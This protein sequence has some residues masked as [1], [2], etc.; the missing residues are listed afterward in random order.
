MRTKPLLMALI[1]LVSLSASQY[2]SPAASWTVGVSKGDYFY[3]KTY[4]AYT[5]NLPNLTLKI[6]QFEYNNTAWLRITVAN[7]SSLVV[8]QAYTLHFKNGSESTFSF[9]TNLNPQNESA[10]KFTQKGVPICAANLKAGDPLPT[11]Q[12]TINKTVIWAYPSGSRETNLV[13]WNCSDD[14]GSCYFD[15]ETGV[16]VELCRTHEF[17]NKATGEFV[18]KTDVLRLVGTNRW[19]VT[20]NQTLTP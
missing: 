16:L 10:L 1:L 5:S 7:V 9:Q 2:I 19:V 4:G 11:V 15:R 20:Q 6:P 18:Q 8:D 17:V 12:L 13:T 14:W 3:Y